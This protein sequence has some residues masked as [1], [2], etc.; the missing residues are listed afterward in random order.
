MMI[1]V[2]DTHVENVK[3]MFQ[4]EWKPLNVIPVA[5]GDGITPYDY[6]KMLKLPISVREKI[7]HFCQ[8]NIIP[9]RY[10]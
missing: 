6:D 9:I 10:Y 4:Q 5:T 8:F 7:T 2:L 3:E 1:L